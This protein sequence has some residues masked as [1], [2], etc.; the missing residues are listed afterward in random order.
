MM[1]FLR[2]DAVG[3]IK[4]LDALYFIP[5]QVKHK[6]KAMMNN[7]HRNTSAGMLT[8]MPFNVVKSSRGIMH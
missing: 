4:S 6:R 1:H 5:V 2:H 7:L 3:R 8:V